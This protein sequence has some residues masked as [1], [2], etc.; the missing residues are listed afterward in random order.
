MILSFSSIPTGELQKL[1]SRGAAIT[2]T[3]PINE[4][5]VDIDPEAVIFICP[6]SPR[7]PLLDQRRQHIDGVAHVGP[8]LGLSDGAV[9]S[10]ATFHIFWKLSSSAESRV[11][12]TVALT[13]FLSLRRQRNHVTRWHFSSGKESSKAFLPV[14][15]SIR[16]TPKAYTSTF[17]VTFPVAVYRLK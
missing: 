7:L 5:H 10:S 6:G 14:I 17:V 2:V 8:M 16:I 13:A 3:V 11:V 9:A 12:S 1:S 15:I 4:A